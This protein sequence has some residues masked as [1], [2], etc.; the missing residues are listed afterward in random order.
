MK[1]FIKEI[2]KI[3]LSYFIN[4]VLY[5]FHII[6]FYNFQNPYF[7]YENPLYCHKF[8]FQILTLILNQ[9]FEFEIFATVYIITIKK[10][11]IKIFLI[12]F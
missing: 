8:F 10:R 3:I 12:R 2:L 4:D 5:F 7:K 9:M 11:Y 6:N 1:L